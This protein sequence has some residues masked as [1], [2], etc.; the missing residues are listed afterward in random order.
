LTAK[1]ETYLK[2]YTDTIIIKDT[3]STQRLKEELE[4]FLNGTSKL[5]SLNDLDQIVQNQDTNDTGLEG[6]RVLLVDD[7]VRNVYALMSFLEQ[8]KMEIAFAENGRESLEVLE[9]SPDFDLILMDIMM[10]EMDGYEAIKRIR[11][12][13]HFSHLPIIALT[14]KAMKE[15]RDKC[16]DAGASDYIVKPFNPDQLISLIRVW[17]YQKGEK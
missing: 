1:E 12:M 16:L 9:K 2:K 11:R 5:S 4:I 6:K 8:Y 17:L 13:T 7:D 15:D 3:Y 10:P 14:A